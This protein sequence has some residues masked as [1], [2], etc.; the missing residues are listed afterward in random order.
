MPDFTGDLNSL[1]LSGGFGGTDNA[2]DPF[3]GMLTAGGSPATPGVGPLLEGAP[4]GAFGSN[5]GP[6]SITGPQGNT[7]LGMSPENF[8]AVAGQLASAIGG[9]KTIGGRVGNLAAQLGTAKLQAL[10]A[11]HQHKNINKFVS[12]LV[13][14]RLKGLMEGTGPATSG[15]VGSS[16]DILNSTPSSFYGGMNNS[17]GTVTT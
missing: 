17:T 12:D 11:E 13:A 8:S 7:I 4:K 15:G 2:V 14:Q 3:A 1:N 16:P 10:A 5:W 6:L 9:P